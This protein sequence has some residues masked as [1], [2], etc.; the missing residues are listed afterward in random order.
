MPSASKN[1]LN[2]VRG[3]TTEKRWGSPTTNTDTGRLQRSLSSL[4]CPSAER[5]RRQPVHRAAMVHSSRLRYRRHGAFQPVPAHLHKVLYRVRRRQLPHI[6]TSP[7][8]P[9]SIEVCTRRYKPVIWEKIP[10]AA[11]ARVPA[12]PREP[13]QLAV[14]KQHPHTAATTLCSMSCTPPYWGWWSINRSKK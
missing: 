1:R 3:Q 8:S 5:F 6:A 4:C 11:L 13:R 12:R 2:L 14:R 9:A 7:P 10:R